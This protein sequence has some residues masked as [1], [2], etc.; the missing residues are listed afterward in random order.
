M[1]K[2]TVSTIQEMLTMS[3]LTQLLFGTAATA[4]LVSLVSVLLMMPVSAISHH[5]L[6]L[7]SVLVT[8]QKRSTKL[9]HYM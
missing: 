9:Q 3:T 4:R 5:T 1:Q 8:L 6:L 2:S 7:A